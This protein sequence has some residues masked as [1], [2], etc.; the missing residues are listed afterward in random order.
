MA[1]KKQEAGSAE[2]VLF[3][4]KKSEASNGGF[5]VVPQQQQQKKK[6]LPVLS[7]EEL[8]LGQA[9]VTR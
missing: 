2:F 3:S 4:G 8:A 5:E 1:T 7:A 9:L 6:R